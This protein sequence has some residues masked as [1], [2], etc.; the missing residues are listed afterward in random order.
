VGTIE[1]FEND[2]LNTLHFNY[3]AQK[4]HIFNIII[5]QAHVK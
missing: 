4:S 2:L 5:R 3:Y 1:N